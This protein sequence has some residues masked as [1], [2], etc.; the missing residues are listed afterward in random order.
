[1][2]SYNSLEPELR[3]LSHGSIFFLL[4]TSAQRHGAPNSIHHHGVGLSGL[5]RMAKASALHTY[6]LSSNMFLMYL[7]KWWLLLEHLDWDAVDTGL[8]YR[9][10]ESPLVIPAR[11]IR[12][13]YIYI[14]IFIL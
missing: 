14:Y 5:I 9:S 4:S 10:V 7:S 6:L 12:W 3:N 13:E 8:G 11:T 1:M 2:T